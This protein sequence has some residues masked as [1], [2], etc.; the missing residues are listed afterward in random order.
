MKITNLYILSLLAVVFTSC[1]SYLDIKPVGKVIPTS[2]DDYRDVM[3]YAYST[4]S[5]DRSLSTVRGDELQLIY[6]DWGDYI[7][8]YNIFIWNDVNTDQN[9]N[10][11]SWQHYYKA[12][13]NANQVILSAEGATDGTQAGIDQL[14]GEAF[15]MRAYM[16]FGLVSLFADTYNSANLN[17]KAIPLATTIDVW[18]NYERNTVGEVYEQ[19]FSDLESGIK[20]LNVDEQ[21]KGLN[22]RFSKVSAYG[23]AARVYAYVGNW[24]KAHEYAKKAYDINHTLVDMNSSTALLPVNYASTENVL[25][26]EQTFVSL[27]KSRFTISDNLLNAFDKENDLRFGKYFER[28]G[29]NYKCSL[30]YKIDNKVSMRTS[31]FYLLLAASEAQVSGG[32]LETAK[33]YLKELL[34]KRLKAA[35]YATEA[36]SIDGMGKDAFLQRV[37][38]ERF[39]ELACQGFRWSDLKFFGQPSITKTFNGESFVLQKNDARYILPFPVEAVE[40]NPNLLN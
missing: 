8:Y 30:G 1:D 25:A 22:Y 27:L 10:S 33:T 16:H 14:R 21:S 37:Q 3:T 20:L 32:N 7:P 31:E 19:I 24:E 23:F 26:M 18:K 17:K 4:V 11:F 40:A 12:I 9:T 28:S 36:A 34:S 29:S 13:L 15:L 5:S 35:F 6:D 2:L 38:E 39:R